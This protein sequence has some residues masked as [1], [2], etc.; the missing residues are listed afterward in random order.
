MKTY[1]IYF[2]LLIFL[3]TFFG[4]A[5]AKPTSD[6]TNS[7]AKKDSPILLAKRNKK[8]RKKGKKRKQ[9]RASSGNKVDA[10]FYKKMNA[11]VKTGTFIGADSSTGGMSLFFGGDFG[12]SISDKL[13][14]AGG[15]LYAGLGPFGSLMLIDGGVYYHFPLGKLMTIAPGIRA[16]LAN[17][18]I[19]FMGTSMS[20]NVFGISPAATFNYFLE[21][22]IL[23]G[24]VRFPLLM[25]SGATSGLLILAFVGITF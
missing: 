22:M 24:E 23:G 14:G 5:T 7:V 25:G 18:T 11:T 8:K 19:S 2:F 3:S 21:P 10:S 12:I 15:L 16:G 13:T 20:M 4:F 1:R 6:P 9:N 17:V